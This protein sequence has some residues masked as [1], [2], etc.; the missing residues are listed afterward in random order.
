MKFEIPLA[1][2]MIVAVSIVLVA[3]VEDKP[4]SIAA[5]AVDDSKFKKAPQLIG[6]TDYINTTPENL[7]QDMKGKVIM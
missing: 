7:T 4:K 1:I 2:C 5:V 3:I 6:I